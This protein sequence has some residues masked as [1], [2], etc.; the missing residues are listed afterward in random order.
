MRRFEAYLAGAAL[1]PAS[2]SAAGEVAEPLPPR[3]PPLRVEQTTDLSPLQPM[4]GLQ[5]FKKPRHSREEDELELFSPVDAATSAVSRPDG[6]RAACSSA[7][8][9]ALPVRR[10]FC[11]LVPCVGTLMLQCLQLGLREGA[12]GCFIWCRTLWL[13]WLQ[14]WGMPCRAWPLRA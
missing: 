3:T 13:Q 6:T 9:A 7:A 10:A 8:G 14:H 1:S 11:M 2:E 4:P 5:A 12:R